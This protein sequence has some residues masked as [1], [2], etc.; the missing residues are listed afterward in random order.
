MAECNESSMLVSE[1]CRVLKRGVQICVLQ[2]M[3]N[4]TCQTT[5]LLINYIIFESLLKGF[6]DDQNL[7]LCGDCR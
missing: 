6:L 5:S 7:L 4:N 3:Q 1:K 2:I